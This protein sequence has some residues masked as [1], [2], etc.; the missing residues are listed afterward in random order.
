MIG[1]ILYFSRGFFGMWL[2][3]PEKGQNM[4][5]AYALGQGTP[6]V[7]P[8][9]IMVQVVQGINDR[10]ATPYPTYTPFPTFTPS[11]DWLRGTPMPTHQSFTPDQVQWVFSYYYPNLVGQDEEKYGLNCHP[12]NVIRNKMGKA[13]ECKDTTA[14]GEPWSKYLMHHAQ[15]VSLTGGVAVPFYPDTYDPI[16]P[17]G[18]LIHVTSPTIMAGT[19]RVIDI[20]P[21]CDDYYRTHG[22][23]FLDFLAKGLPEGVT[24]WDS[25]KVDSVIYPN[26]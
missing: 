11:V 16:Y 5:L 13:I 12:D 7:T 25:V 14:S 4:G 26:E 8:T 22:V 10:T 17:M 6:T 19:Y 24:F 20:C 23:V 1:I 3:N 21:A 9:L 2:P 15:D 18:T